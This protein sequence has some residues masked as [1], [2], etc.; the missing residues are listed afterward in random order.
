MASLVCPAREEKD[1]SYKLAHIR[2]ASQ[3]VT[4]HV[5][6]AVKKNAEWFVLT[7]EGH[8]VLKSADIPVLAVEE[9]PDFA[10]N[11]VIKS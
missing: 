8:L 10:E 2:N 5:N 3:N 7:V 9:N 1:V 11:S 6:Q 4:I